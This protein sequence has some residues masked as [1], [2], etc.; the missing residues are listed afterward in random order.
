[1]K[2]AF[3]A[4]KTCI[5]AAGSGS[6][7]M[8]QSETATKV[9]SLSKPPHNL[10]Y[11]G[12]ATYDIESSREKQTRA[13]LDQG[14][15]VRSLNLVQPSDK[16]E[17]SIENIQKQFQWASIVLVSGGNTLFAIDAWKSHAVDE[18]LKRAAERGVVL[19]GGSAGAIC[20]FDGGHSD[21]HDPSTYKDAM[22]SRGDLPST[23]E[24]DAHWEYIR[25][26]GLGLLPGLCCPHHD[27]TQSN[28]LPRASDFDEM[29]L[30]HSGETGICL[31]H[32]ASLVIQG[33][34]YHVFTIPGKGGSSV[35][36]TDGETKYTTSGDGQ[37]AVWKK[38]V[39]DGKVSLYPIPSSG[40]CADLFTPAVDIVDDARVAQCRKRNPQWK[41]SS[42][43]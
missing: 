27:R 39:Q 22:L 5:L 24:S 7:F 29:L 1:M 42:S 11:L 38:I 9:L 36:T 6:G 21:S 23:E 43:G 14:C 20:W 15:A 18:A 19:C 25:V 26:P 35:R 32:W 2:K 41:A 10:L 34:D 37:P 33:E 16:E 40:K 28:G 30:R 12:T 8:A 3:G 31:D 4:A 13:F 17:L